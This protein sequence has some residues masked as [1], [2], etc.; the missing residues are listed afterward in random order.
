MRVE[1]ILGPPHALFQQGPWPL[2]LEDQPPCSVLAR[3]AL[4]HTLGELWLASPDPNRGGEYSLPLS[5]YPRGLWGGP[6]GPMIEVLWATLP[7]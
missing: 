4:I 6:Y 3:E 7:Y 5:S 2:K 1:G